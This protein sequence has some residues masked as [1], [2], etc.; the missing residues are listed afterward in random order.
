MTMLHSQ[1]LE[2]L[3]V[4]THTHQDWFDAEAEHCLIRASPAQSVPEGQQLKHKEN[5]LPRYSQG[6]PAETPGEPMEDQGQV[7][8]SRQVH[9]H[10]EQTP[11]WHDGQ[12]QKP[13]RAPFPIT[14]G[15]KQ[16]CM[17]APPLFSMIFSAMLQDA[18]QN[19]PEISFIYHC[20]SGKLNLWRKWVKTKV[21]EATVWELVIADDCALA[22]VL[23]VSMDYFSSAC[24]N[25]SRTIST[26]MTEVLYQP[27]PGKLYAEP[28]ISVKEQKLS[29]TDKFTY[30][31][32]SVCAYRW[33]S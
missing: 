29:A 3:S 4:P 23:Q 20:D 14:N 6:S 17:L 16:G 24:N 12:H 8:L 2:S 33:W 19:N 11:W 5:C 22:N 1:A 31:S 30:N 13:A 26:K 15:V 25:F 10:S 9:W 7:Q 32:V 27:A 21:K 18:F 28:T